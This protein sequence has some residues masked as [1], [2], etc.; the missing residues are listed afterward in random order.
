[1]AAALRTDGVRDDGRSEGDAV[2]AVGDILA[3]GPGRK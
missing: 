3:E 2:G 1:M